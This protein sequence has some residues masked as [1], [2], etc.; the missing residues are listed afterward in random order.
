MPPPDAVEG[1]RRL[2]ER[3]SGPL[4][5]ADGPANAISDR[6]NAALPWLWWPLSAPDPARRLGPRENALYALH[7]LVILAAV[8]R[9]GLTA[10]LGPAAALGAASWLWFTGAWNRRAEAF[11][12]DAPVQSLR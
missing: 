10:P 3:L 6:M 4:S 12:R 2:A 1:E 9:A 11:D 8:R 5:A 7:G